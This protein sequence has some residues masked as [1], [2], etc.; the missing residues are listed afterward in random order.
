MHVCDKSVT[1]IC[2]FLFLSFGM[3]ESGADSELVT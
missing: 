1:C 2:E 3:T